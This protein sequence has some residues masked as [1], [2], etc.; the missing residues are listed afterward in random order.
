MKEL[1]HI[2]R[3]DLTMLPNFKDIGGKGTYSVVTKC[4]AGYPCI[5]NTYATSAYQV[6]KRFDDIINIS[7]YEPEIN[8]VSFQYVVYARLGKK[9]WINAKL[10]RK[11]K[12]RD[13]DEYN[14]SDAF[15]NDVGHVE[16]E[17]DKIA[18]LSENQR[19]AV[20]A[21][22]AGDNVFVMNGNKVNK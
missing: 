8:D 2:K 13:V 22:G 18:I 21:H 20:N 14:F 16:S 3:E 15:S 17:F 7:Q 10:A 11:L 12:L 4:K 9:V 6:F 19:A 1:V 5:T